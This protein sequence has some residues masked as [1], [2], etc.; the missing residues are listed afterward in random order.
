MKEIVSV[1][2]KIMLIIIIH[3]SYMHVFFILI[4]NYFMECT[5]NMIIVLMLFLFM[6]VFACV[7][8]SLFIY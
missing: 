8:A 6:L 2:A 7:V 5:E 4:V 1:C 3:H